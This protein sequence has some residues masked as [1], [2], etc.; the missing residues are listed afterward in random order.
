MGCVGLLRFTRYDVGSLCRLAMTSIRCV[1][2]AMTSNGGQHLAKTVYFDIVKQSQIVNCKFK[3]AG[4]HYQPS[5]SLLVPLPLAT[6]LFTCLLLCRP[7]RGTGPTPNRSYCLLPYCLL[8]TS[9][10]PQHQLQF[11]QQCI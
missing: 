1:L 4:I 9:L 10:K 3:I 7:V 6:H 5:Y 8:L 11:Y 2:L